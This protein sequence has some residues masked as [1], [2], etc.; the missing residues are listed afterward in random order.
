MLRISG[1]ARNCA[2]LGLASG[3]VLVLF[4]TLYGC[5][6]T[7]K[8]PTDAQVKAAWAVRQAR[9]SQQRFWRISGKVAVTHESEG[10]QAG[11]RWQQQNE[12]F[13]IEILDPIGRKIAQIRGDLD[14]VQL[15]TSKGRSAQAPNAESLMRELL[16]WSL[17]VSG[18]RYWVIGIP[19]P[20][21]NVEQLQLD[22][23]G[24][25]VQLKQGAWDVRYQYYTSTA[26]VDLPAKM[27]LTSERLRLTLVVRDWRLTTA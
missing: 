10:W 2:P 5:A 8:A 19:D 4:S 14:M 25:I 18:M 15:K 1:Q 21:V 13:N 7:P 17:P 9:L 20:R 12:R 11:L 16:G 26:D 6:T 27:T 23:I 22:D 3:L 24:R